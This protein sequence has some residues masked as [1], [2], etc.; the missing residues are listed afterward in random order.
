M[1]IVQVI[2]ARDLIAGDKLMTDQGWREVKHTEQGL[3]DNPAGVK[4]C[5]DWDEEEFYAADWSEIERTAN[6]VVLR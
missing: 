3:Y 5:W 1:K 4:L 6:V 2:Q